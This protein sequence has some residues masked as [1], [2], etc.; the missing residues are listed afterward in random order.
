MKLIIVESQAKTKTIEKILGK[1]YK[2]V[3]SVGHIKKI[4]DTGKF[5]LGIDI[6]NEF[7][8]NYGVDKDHV[9]VV[10]EL[11]KLAT[12]AEEIF[13]ATDPDREGESIASALMVELDLNPED[14][15]RIIFNEIT[16]EP[17][18]K[19]L[20]HPGKIDLHL[21]ESAQTRQALDKIIGY[22]LSRLLQSKSIA[23][24]AGRVQSVALMLVVEKEEEI[25]AFIPDK[26]Y[27]IKPTIK[28]DNDEYNLEVIKVTDEDKFDEALAFEANE[29]TI[30]SIVTKESK[31]KIKIAFTTSTLQ[32]TAA[33][34]LGF[35]VSKTMNVAQKLYEGIN[36]DGELT[37]LITYMRTDS[38]RLSDDFIKAGMGY[39]EQNLGKEYVQGYFAK[40]K[41][42]N[43]QDAHEGVRV[44]Y[45]NHTP[46]SIKGNLTP[47]QYKLY[48]MIWER[49]VACVTKPPVYNK[50]TITF[51]ETS[52]FTFK[53]KGSQLIFPG[54]LKVETSKD[55]DLILPEVNVG[56]TYKLVNLLK[57]EDYTRPPAR[58]SE[59]RLVKTL[60]ELGIGRPSTYAV[61]ID[62]L[63][64]RNYVEVIDRSFKPTETAFDINVALKQYFNDIINVEY[65]ANMENKLDEIADNED[66]YLN[67]LQNFYPAFNE[68]IEI[69]QEKMEKKPLVEIGRKCPECGHELVERKNKRTGQK[70]IAC[71]N[72]PKC[73][74]TEA[75]NEV[76]DA[77]QKI[78]DKMEELDIKC[79]TCGGKLVKKVTKTRKV[80]YGCENY[81]ECE[82]S[83]W[84][85][86]LI[87]KIKETEQK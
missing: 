15:N 47:D 10:R 23:Q 82:Y 68:K 46:E 87:K 2:V 14:N 33:S 11:K 1:D 7:E 35:S 44:S 64:S 8:I 25:S 53:L 85:N 31:S 60:E 58:Y 86:Q 16:P 79:E 45:I 73:K 77:D 18:K 75:T 48:K 78:L 36:I 76:S 83:I 30:D 54:F 34:K 41:K 57:E 67:T 4:K 21:V 28:I 65:T 49:S 52:P 6:D 20:E 71:S 26:F 42:A 51:V 12:E 27:N 39:V 29:L 13:I 74:Y 43:I 17:I 37:G 72:F 59:A 70:F 69:A 56:E 61:T 40:P 3:A 19:A 50:T 80:F 9:K 38:T 32:Q 55:D 66:T 5:R 22:R 62:I 63:K 81:P 84:E 24:S